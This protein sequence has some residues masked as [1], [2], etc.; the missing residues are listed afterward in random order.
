ADMAMFEA[1][2][3]RLGVRVFDQ[4]L[5]DRRLREI[6]LGR[7]IA[8]AVADD[9]FEVH[10]QPIVDVRTLE[11]VALE[12][13]T[14]WPVENLPQDGED[15]VAAAEE[16]GQIIA[17]GLNAV[18]AARKACTDFGLPVGVNVSPRQLAEPDLTAQ[19]LGA[20]GDD[21]RDRLTL[22]ITESALLDDLPLGIE[23]LAALRAEG[24]RIALDDFGTGY[25]SLARLAHLPVDV[26]K[27]DRQFATDSVSSRGRAVLRGIIEIAHAS[28]LLV[29]VEGVETVEQL[30]TIT[31]LGADRVQGY[32]VGRASMQ[33]PTPVTLPQ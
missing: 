24:V 4:G 21:D 23:T 7:R 19:L 6:D 26:L 11:V 25:S 17:I 14:R 31:E 28:G 29:V 33:A 9:E 18:R 22:E 3:K 16:S 10:F 15:W 12:A 20:W 1:K 32:L 13:L 27:V 5:R 2:H 8:R 30:E